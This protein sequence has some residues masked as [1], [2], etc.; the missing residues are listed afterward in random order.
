MK[1]KKELQLELLNFTIKH[2]N[3]NNRG[4]QKEN[5]SYTAGC[6]IGIHLPIE[7]RKEFDGEP[8]SDIM[9]LRKD[10]FSLWNKIPENLK[11]CGVEFL[12]NIQFLHDNALNWN[13]EG[14]NAIGLKEVERIKSRF[15]LL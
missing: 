10:N 5:C 11:D 6:A 9:S 8:N 12:D 15:Y 1:T 14:L 2:F 4:V 7:L 3:S 13:Q